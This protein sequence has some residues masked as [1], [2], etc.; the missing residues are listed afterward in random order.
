MN[1]SV[2]WYVLPELPTP[3]SNAPDARKDARLVLW[4]DKS[5]QL[6][7]AMYNDGVGMGSTVAMAGSLM[8]RALS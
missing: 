3:A 7:P 6:Q 1:S 4:A 2:A 8:L 5:L